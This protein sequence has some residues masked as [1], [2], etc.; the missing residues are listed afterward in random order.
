MDQSHSAVA[1]LSLTTTT[2][3]SN[4]PPSSGQQAP[5]GAENEP[6]QP[7]VKQRPRGMSKQRSTGGTPSVGSGGAPSGGSGAAPPLR[8]QDSARKKFAMYD[9]DDDE[10]LDRIRR[11]QKE[12]E[13]NTRGSYSLEEILGADVPATTILVLQQLTQQGARCDVQFQPISGAQLCRTTSPPSQGAA[14]PG[15]ARKRTESNPP[16]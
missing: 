14:D 13:R 8:R 5:S 4:G 1:N 7:A 15:S 2:L 12:K 10:E 16:R 11:K 9:V 6:V 3:R